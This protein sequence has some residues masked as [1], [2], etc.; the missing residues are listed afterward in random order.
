M[1]IQ[2]YEGGG[3]GE[4][5]EEESDFY[6]AVGGLA[7]EEAVKEWDSAICLLVV[8]IQMSQWVETVEVV[9][10]QEHC[11]PGEKIMES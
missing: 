3:P 5:S 7:A 2:K 10:W 9:M 1:Q 8:F 11:R 6:S 4:E